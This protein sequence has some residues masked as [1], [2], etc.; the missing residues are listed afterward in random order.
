MELKGKYKN[1]YDRLIKANYGERWAEQKINK[2]IEEDDNKFWEKQVY[3]IIQKGAEPNEAFKKIEI[4]RKATVNDERRESFVKMIEWNRNRD[5]ALLE[6][7][8]PKEK[9]EDGAWYDCEDEAKKVARFGG[10]AQWN[11]KR[12]EFLAPGQQQFGMN[13]WLEHWADV[14]DEGY[15]GFVPMWK[16]E[17]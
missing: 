11:E 13:G 3:Q 2:F 12:Q 15:A 7:A 8:I 9:L 10:K 4:I 5:L 16:V 17:E 14:V 1:W 6:K